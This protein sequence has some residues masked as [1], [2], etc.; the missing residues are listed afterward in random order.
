VLVTEQ[1]LTQ[2]DSLRLGRSWEHT[3]PGTGEQVG[4]V[5]AAVRPLLS[6]CPIADDVVLVMSELATNAVR[7]SASRDGTFT[8]R[9]LHI[10]GD[11]VFG[12]VEDG[13]SRWDGQAGAS[14]GTGQMTSSI[15]GTS[16]VGRVHH[17]LPRLRAPTRSVLFLQFLDAA[18]DGRGRERADESRHDTHPDDT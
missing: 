5:R 2:A 12:E 9:L 7:H 13:G 18:S 10:P 8:A 6:D 17:V 1:T 16:N 11:Y 4:R 3:Y 14:K 15:P